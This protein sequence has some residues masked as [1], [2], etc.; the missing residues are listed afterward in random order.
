MEIGLFTTA[1]GRVRG[2]VDDARR[3][4]AEGFALFVLANIRAHDAL[5][6]LAVAGSHTRHIRLLTGVVP[7]YTRH[8]V[9]MAQ[10][11]RTTQAAAEGRFTLGIGLS[12][13]VNVEGMLG[14]SFDRPAAHMRDYLAVLMPL[15][16][17]EAVEFEGEHFT[18]RGA[19]QTRDAQPVPCLIAAMAP[20]MLRLAGER[21]D[22]TI[23]WMTAAAAIR[24][25]V[26]PRVLKAAA[27]AGRP[28]PQIVCMLPI[29]L[30]A[31]VRSARTR[32]SAEF[33]NYG[34]LPSYRAMLD[35]AGA[36]LPGDAAIVGDEATVRDALEELRDIGVTA[37][38]GMLFDDGTGS[39]ERTRAFLAS[40]A[41][42]I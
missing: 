15:L 6:A 28:R 18:Y 34:N 5:G 24:D 42:A 40:L 33:A 23:L 38:A 3:A 12:H 20:V 21:A 7:T 1:G 17:G 4:E 41:P 25:H 39:V 19:L 10:A 36:V 9:A 26:A 31:D 32:A 11:A 27:V 35:K 22:G 14:M 16:H 2:I 8:P 37:F 13:R 30:T 29:T